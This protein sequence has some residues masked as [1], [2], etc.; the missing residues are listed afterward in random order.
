MPFVGAMIS[1]NK[2]KKALIAG[3][4]TIVSWVIIDNLLIEISFW[5]YLLI[6]LVI[7]LL[8]QG[9]KYQVQKLGLETTERNEKEESEPAQ[10]QDG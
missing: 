9:Y 1:K 6:E 4:F 7:G 3:V 10:G 5:K 8:E 2:I